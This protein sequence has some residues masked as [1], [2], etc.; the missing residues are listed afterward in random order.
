MGPLVIYFAP[1][2]YRESK[3]STVKIMDVQ[4][5]QGGVVALRL[6]KPS[7][8][9]GH[10]RAGMYA[11]LNI[12]SVSRS[13]WH[14]F[15]LTSAPSDDYI[16]FHFRQAGD[17]TK[18]AHDFFDNFPSAPSTGLEE[19]P[20]RLVPK[21]IDSTTIVKVDGP[22]GASS[23]GFSD[24]PVIVLVGAGIGVTPM[25]SVLRMLLAN[26]GKMRRTFF[27]WTVRD[28]DSFTWFT[29]LMDDVYESDQKHVL[30]TRHFL[31]SVKDDDRDLGAVLLHHATRAMHKQTDID[32]LLGN[33]T[34]HQVEVGRPNWDE[35]LRSV[36]DEAKQLGFNKCGIFLCGPEK[37]ADALRETST[38][39]SR[40][41]TNF[42]MY[43]TKET[44]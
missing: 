18:K 27:Y 6:N 34:H 15:T 29:S 33:R 4:I 8:W 28:R 43:F 13:E 35:E 17:W 42:H 7:S 23:Q 5:K 40:E 10:V 39:L 1:R 21:D 41:D 14:P 16:E 24:Y 12:P 11:F 26:P 20:Q 3:C 2:L 36:Q 9:E 32:L 30:Q 31:T 25:I 38:K 19:G 22:I 44:F 37:M